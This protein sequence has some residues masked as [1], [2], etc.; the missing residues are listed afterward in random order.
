L[1]YFNMML[2]DYLDTRLNIS[3]DLYLGFMGRIISILSLTLLIFCIFYIAKAFYNIALHPLRAYPGP[4]LWRA[5]YLPASYHTFRGTY[6]HRLR[7]IHRR[8]GATV[9]VTPNELSFTSEQA[10]RELWL[11]RRGL[12]EFPKDTR[13]FAKPANGIS[14]IF[15]ADKEP[16]KRYRRLLA[17]AFSEKGLREQEPLMKGYVGLLIDRLSDQARQGNTVDLVEWFNIVTFDIIG[18]LA[19][20]DPFNSLRDNNLHPWI[21]AAPAA[22]KYGVKASLI[23]AH[24]LSHEE[25]KTILRLLPGWNTQPMGPRILHSIS[26]S[27]KPGCRPK[28]Q[29]HVRQGAYRPS[30]PTHREA[31]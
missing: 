20:G 23:F 9:R 28:R 2:S 26:G 25:V 30:D 18:D 13:A 24:R 21:K 16:H 3:P 4:P 31:R 17:P 10:M 22:L 7:E 19:F 5:S 15:F 12:E 14:N 27:P 29:F 11:Y 1:K 8:Y 6:H